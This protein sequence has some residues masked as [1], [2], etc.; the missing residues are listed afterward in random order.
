MFNLGQIFTTRTVSQSL[1]FETIANLISRH[2][3]GDWGDLSEDDK[4][5]NDEALKTNDRIFSAYQVEDERVY[6]ITEWDRSATTVLY[7][8]EY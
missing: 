3:S 1:G 6:I 8:D 2:H 5:L 7:S 4:A